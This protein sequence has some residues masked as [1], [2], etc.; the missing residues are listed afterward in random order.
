MKF[1]LEC[2]VAAVVGHVKSLG[3]VL[4]EGGNDSTRD[5]L[6]NPEYGNFS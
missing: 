1:R 6:V 3:V 4:N 5:S 2:G